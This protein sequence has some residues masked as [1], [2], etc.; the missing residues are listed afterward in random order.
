MA[1]SES[2]VPNIYADDLADIQQRRCVTSRESFRRGMLRSELVADFSY[3]Y[4][5]DDRI[6]LPPALFWLA[7]PMSD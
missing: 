3:L 7:Y 2:H 4:L 5:G 1:A 6:L